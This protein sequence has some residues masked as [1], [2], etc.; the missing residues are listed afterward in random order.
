[1]SAHVTSPDHE[2]GTLFDCLACESGCFCEEL[3]ASAVADA[4]DTEP[5]IC[6]CCAIG[7][8]HMQA[9]ADRKF[10]RRN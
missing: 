1:M 5:T 2:A 8:E 4:E 9:H 6:V 10:G 3:Q 7:Q